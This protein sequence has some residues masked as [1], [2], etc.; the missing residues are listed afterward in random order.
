MTPLVRALGA[1]AAVLL[2]AAPAIAQQ[3]GPT[4]ARTLAEDLQLFSQVLNQIRVNHPDTMDTH[5]M[6]MA[7]IE[8]LVGAVDP[9]SFVI[10]AVRLDSARQ[11]ALEAGKLAPVPISFVYVGGVPSVLSVAP[12]THASRQDI[13][14]GDEL[15]AIDGAPV[16]AGSEQELELTLAGAKGSSVTLRLRR[17]RFDGSQATVERSVRREIADETTAVPMAHMLDPLTGYVRITT[18][19]NAKVEDD[20]HDALARLEK[21]GMTRLI[22]DLRDNGGGL[23][24]EAGE[25]AGEFLPR[26]AVVYTTEGRKDAVRKTVKVSRSFWQRGKSYPIVVM[27]NR[28]TASASELVAGALQDHDRALIV[29]RPSFGKALLM[30]GMPLSDGSL[31]MLVI[32]HVKTPCG[33]VVQR[34]YR[35]VRTG[36]YYRNADADRDTTGRPACR[37]A[38]GRTVY[39]GGGIYPDIVLPPPAPVPVWLTQLREREIPVRWAGTQ[40]DVPGAA[41]AMVDAYLNPQ[42]V[43]PAALSQFREY[44]R[45][46]GVDV[47]PGEDVELRLRQELAAALARAKIGDAG[48]YRVLLEHD[49]WIAPAV[50]AFERATLL[51][52]PAAP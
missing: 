13:V 2:S 49:P 3:P 12:A 17:R 32:G 39:G 22:L 11:K 4:R 29:G 44:A 1:A 21:A 34:Q 47:P 25:V 50:Q 38:A 27:T 9:H 42:L 14:P 7:A 8:A 37:T 20:L 40:L 33:R 6:M 18:F 52:G 46:G 31:M 10:P 19:A 5:A 30:Q 23:V 28:G 26:G 43:N 16:V 35:G 36:D 15:E 41:P 24:K 48:Y 45:A 51:R